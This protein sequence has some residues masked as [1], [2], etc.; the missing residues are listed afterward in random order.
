MDVSLHDLYKLSIAV[1]FHFLSFSHIC[2]DQRTQAHRW[3]VGIQNMCENGDEESLTDFLCI[4][5]SIFYRD[6][7]LFRFYFLTSHPPTAIYLTNT[8]E[9]MNLTTI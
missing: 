1:V 4:N 8:I 5:S 6:T 9:L 7:E 2:A 3:V